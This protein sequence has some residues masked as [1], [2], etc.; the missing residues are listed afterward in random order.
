MVAA[1]RINVFPSAQ[2]RILEVLLDI[3]ERLCDL[4]REVVCINATIIVPSTLARAFDNV[5]DTDSLRVRVLAFVGCAD[6]GIG[7]VL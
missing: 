6:A 7:V 4:S 5:S 1:D 2:S 3:L